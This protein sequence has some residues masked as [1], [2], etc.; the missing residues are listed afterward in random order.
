M[1]IIGVG[2]VL[3]SS[4][5]DPKDEA[6]SNFTVVFLPLHGAGPASGR[7]ERDHRGQHGARGHVRGQAGP[8]GGTRRP[9]PK[10]RPGRAARP[11]PSQRPPPAGSPLRSEG[12]CPASRPLRRPGPRPT[13]LTPR[14]TRCSC[15]C[16]TRAPPTPST[17]PSPSTAPNAPPRVATRRAPPSPLP[18]GFRWAWPPGRRGRGGATEAGATGAGGT[19]AASVGAGP[20][21]AAPSSHY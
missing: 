1:V 20:V 2:V 3:T 4:F 17:S 11:G 5:Q 6:V 13:S 7:R 16:T 12:P 14:L 18:P 8:R 19:G 10:P 21:A 15:W 9:H